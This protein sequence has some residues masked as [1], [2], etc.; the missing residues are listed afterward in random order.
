MHTRLKQSD[1]SG[2]G[3]RLGRKLARGWMH[4][5][6]ARRKSTQKFTADGAAH[7]S[8][9]ALRSNDEATTALLSR[10]SP[11]PRVARAR[12][13]FLE[14]CHSSRAVFA[15]H[16]PRR[17]Y[18]LSFMIFQYTKQTERNRD[19]FRPGKN[20]VILPFTYTLSPPLTC[21]LA[22]T[23][24]HLASVRFPRIFVNAGNSVPNDRRKSPLH[25]VVSFD[26]INPFATIV[27]RSAT[28]KVYTLNRITFRF[29]MEPFF[30]LSGDISTRA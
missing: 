5:Y 10:S 20:Y 28:T 27:H 8:I 2:R 15:S 18:K 30:E 25:K 17:L 23:A 1:N 13:P 22:C 3:V 16:P 29:E 12:L 7:S 26:F 19:I 14:Y 9:P 4:R 21:P 11:S 6:F 24:F